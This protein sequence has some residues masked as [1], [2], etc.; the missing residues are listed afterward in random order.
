MSR[1]HARTSA[2]TPSRRNLL[3]G[4]GALAVLGPALAALGSRSASGATQTSP[5]LDF[6]G[7]TLKVVCNTPHTSMYNNFLAPAWRQLTGGTLQAT[8]VVYT[9]LADTIIQDVR[10]GTG[11]FDCFDY[12]YYML[13][14][15][16]DAGA[17]VVQGAE[18][19]ES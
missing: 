17:L 2:V 5:S 15:I 1:L 3:R 18:T 6:E 12:Y 11:Q 10:S 16:A 7:V 4:A 8:G 14:S 13:G 19:V 9:Q